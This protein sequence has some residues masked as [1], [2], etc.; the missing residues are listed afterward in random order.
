M[1]CLGLFLAVSMHVG[2]EANY[3]NVHPHARCT[4][5]NNIAGVFYNSE[6]RISTYIGKEFELDEYWNIELGLV[7]GYKSED[8][9][10]M[11]RYKAGGLFVSPAYEKHNGE[12]NYGVVIGWEI[13]K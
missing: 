11:I 9:L 12:E 1:N 8:I 2:L 10:P 6:D 3:N 13:G 4:V 7:T 5:D